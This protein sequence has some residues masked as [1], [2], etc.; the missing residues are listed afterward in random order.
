VPPLR[1]RIDDIPQLCGFILHNLKRKIGTNNVR[2]S[3][4]AMHQLLQYDWP[5][6]VR[7]LQH[8]L[9]RSALRAVAN[10]D[11]KVGIIELKHLGLDFVADSPDVITS[12]APAIA[13]ENKS[14]NEILT[15]FQ[16]QLI[17]QAMEDND[18]VWAKAARQLQLDRGNLY[19]QAK[20]LGLT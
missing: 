11:G 19:R 15:D 14:F 3:K 13:T 16:R 8:V 5:G 2:V 17:T 4:T 20:R 10:A 7:E 6:N 1:E 9:M 18:H 12:I